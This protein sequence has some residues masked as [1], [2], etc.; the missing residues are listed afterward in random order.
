MVGIRAGVRLGQREA[1]ELAT[2]GEVG[3]E[4][5]LLVVGA[6]QRD[7]LE[8]DRLVH[9]EDDR[10]RWIDLR[11]RLEHAAVAGLGETLA[12]VLLRNVE[13]EDAA[14][15][16]LEDELVADPAILLG[17]AP[18]VVLIGA[19]AERGDQTADLLALLVARAREREDDVLVDLA[20]EEGL[21]EGGDVPAARGVLSGGGGLGLGGHASLI[22]TAATT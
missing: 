22:A 17:L 15:A 6:E 11:D 9:P 10:E 18:V 13:P 19:L 3:E 20:E 8:A 21:R 2:A 16:E 1:G 14:L 7:A 4:T 5:L 12:A